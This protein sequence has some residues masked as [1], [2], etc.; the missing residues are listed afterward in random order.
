MSWD[1][2]A[3]IDTGGE[4]PARVGE[5]FNYTYNTS[6]MLY[7]VGI[8]WNELTGKPLTEVL[9][10]LKT[11]L[12]VLHAEPERFKAMNPPNGWGSYDGLCRVLQEVIAEFE[13]HPKAVLGSCL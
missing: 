4:H 1:I 3:E 11:G 6:R 10:V 9:P 2:W 7:A 5:S 8:D 13:K 12:G